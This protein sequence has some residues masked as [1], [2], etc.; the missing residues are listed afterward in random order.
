MRFERA[1]FGRDLSPT[2]RLAGINPHLAE[3]GFIWVQNTMCHRP[4]AYAHPFASA[5][6]ERSPASQALPS[7]KCNNDRKRNN[8]TDLYLILTVILSETTGGLNG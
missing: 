6:P 8:Q 7:Q 1:L 4:L 5:E 3:V 2:S